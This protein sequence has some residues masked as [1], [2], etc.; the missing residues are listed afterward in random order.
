MAVKVIGVGFGRTGTLSLK[1]ALE[2]LGFGKCYH[3]TELL[4]HPDHIE[5]WETASRGEPVAWDALFRGYQAAVDFPT[6]HFYEPIMAHYPHARVIL[7]VRNP[8]EWYDS[9]LHTIYRTEPDWWQKISMG[10]RLPFSPRLQQTSRIFKLAQETIWAG[11]FEDRFETDKQAA[12]DLYCGH[13]ETIKRTIPPDKLLV[14]NVKRGWEPLCEFLGVSVPD[15]PFPRLNHR[16]V[17]A[18]Y[19][20]ELFARGMGGNVSN[21]GPVEPE[22]MLVSAQEVGSID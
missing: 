16:A 22:R 7:T 20:R 15:K 13:I 4:S 3:M 17:F 2:D 10:F 11:D 6:Y 5:H 19:N 18:E 14:Y 12:V 1:A 9:A 21:N 8:E